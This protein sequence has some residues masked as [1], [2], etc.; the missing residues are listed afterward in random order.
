MRHMKKVIQIGITF[1]ICY[2]LPFIAFFLLLCLCRFIIFILLILLG[3]I[4][5]FKLLKVSFAIQGYCC[6]NLY[7]L[8]IST[9]PFCHEKHTQ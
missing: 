6:V 3:F 7:L 8:K 9:M 5:N 1:N 2:L 4:P